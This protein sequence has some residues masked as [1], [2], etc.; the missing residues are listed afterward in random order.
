VRSRILGPSNPKV[1]TRNFQLQFATRFFRWAHTRCPFLKVLIW[2]TFEENQDD[3]IL[4]AIERGHTAY[5][6]VLEWAPQ[7]CFVKKV[8]ELDN[9]ILQITAARATRNRIRHD[10]PEFNILDYDTGSTLECRLAD[11]AVC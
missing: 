6:C 4:D 8:I 1:D 2:G 5:G 11:E 9:G 3:E 10:F 7:Q